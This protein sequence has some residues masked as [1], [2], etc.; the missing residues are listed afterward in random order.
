[1]DSRG[2]SP[3]LLAT[4]R[5]KVSATVPSGRRRHA[6]HASGQPSDLPGDVPGHVVHERGKLLW[7][8][9]R[10][11]QVRVVAQEHKGVDLDSVLALRT[12]DDA[13]DQVIGTQARP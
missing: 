3:E 9:G 4:P 10:E 5:R 12:I 1:M 11:Q 6:G 2:S 7:G 13:D 8:V